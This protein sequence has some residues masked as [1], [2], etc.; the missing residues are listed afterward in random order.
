M[1]DAPSAGGGT[2]NIAGHKVKK[3]T[4]AIVGIG[5]VG[6][7]GIFYLR[8]RKAANTANAAPS[9]AVSTTDAGLVTD[10]AGN[11]CAALDPA[12]GYCP[13]TAE[14]TSAMATMNTEAD[15]GLGVTD[16]GGTFDFTPGPTGFTSNAAWAQAAESAM[17]SSGS[18]AIAAALG[19]YLTGA[20]MS[21]TDVQ[22]AQEAIAIEGYPPVGG[23]DGYPPSM[24]TAT[25]T[26]NPPPVVGTQPAKVSVPNVVGGDVDSAVSALERAGLKDQLTLVRKAGH[27]YIVTGQNPKAGASVAVG[28]TV[29]I[30]AKE[31]A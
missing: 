6:I 16:N 26:G 20:Q 24:H 27:T 1:A 12:T 14:D 17:G 18:D 8:E 5:V 30:N 4:A 15:N 9:S 31:K 3:S 28:S 21:A 7:A 2:F 23:P 22:N 13:G 29:T 25:T 10:P 11:T 19:H